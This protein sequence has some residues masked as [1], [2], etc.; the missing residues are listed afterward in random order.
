[1]TQEHI[2]SALDALT[3]AKIGLEAELEGIAA[4][5]TPALHLIPLFDRVQKATA[6][7][8]AFAETVGADD[9]LI[10]EGRALAEYFSDASDRLVLAGRPN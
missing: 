10:E 2:L 8:I 9:S 7:L 5:E 1:M 4:R 3:T 6:E